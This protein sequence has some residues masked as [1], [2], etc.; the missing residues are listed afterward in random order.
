MVRE[1]RFRQVDV[2]ADSPFAGNPLAVI[3]D[4]DDLDTDTMQRIA[5]WTNLSETTFLLPPSEPTADYRVRIFTLFG[6]LPFA[7]HPTLGSAAVWL[8]AGGSPRRDGVVVQECGIGTVEVR[9]D[10]SSL[11]FAAPPLIRSGPPSPDEVHDVADLLGISVDD[12]IEAR[13]IDNGPGW[14]GVLLADAEAVLALRPASTADRIVAIGVVGPH[15]PGV[16]PAYEVRAV[17]SDDTGAIR[18]DPV[19][20]SL[21][22]SVA[23]WMIDSGRVTPPYIARQGTAIGRRGAIH[24]SA[25]EGDLWIGGSVTP[26]ITGTIR[27]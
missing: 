1:R 11:A 14:I 12:I 22:A 15:R 3:V 18:E 21:N 4:G 13:W 23:Q 5:R 8:A 20:G 26:I 24:V 6:E 10:G 19:T 27:C 2:F 9:T 16:G 7:G 25:A 17:F